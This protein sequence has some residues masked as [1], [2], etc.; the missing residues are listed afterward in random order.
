MSGVNPLATSP[1]GIKLPL[2]GSLLNCWP[3]NFEVS[4]SA[5][6]QNSTTTT[7]SQ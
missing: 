5:I 3:T 4:P 6:C 7:I 1:I 2:D